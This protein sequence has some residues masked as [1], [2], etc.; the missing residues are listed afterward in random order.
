MITL[1]PNTAANAQVSLVKDASTGVAYA[2]VDIWNHDPA[3]AAVVTDALPTEKPVLAYPDFGSFSGPA[4]AGTRIY[5][6]YE[7]SPFGGTTTYMGTTA[8]G[9]DHHQIKVPV[10]DPA[11]FMQHLSDLGVVLS[12]PTSSYG[13]HGTAWINATVDTVF[14]G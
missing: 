5:N 2:V 9:W 14:I 13:A 4:F 6:G 11:Y 7:F 1:N 10:S 8:D 3:I 12:V